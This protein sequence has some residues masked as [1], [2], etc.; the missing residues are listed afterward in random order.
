MTDSEIPEIVAG[1]LQLQPLFGLVLNDGTTATGVVADWF[2]AGR[3]VWAARDIV[4]ALERAFVAV[5]AIA[6]GTAVDTVVGAHGDSA[7]TVAAGEVIARY[8]ESA[9]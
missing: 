8:C 7:D 6:P 2:A 3:L 9:G 4:T 1:N 5:D